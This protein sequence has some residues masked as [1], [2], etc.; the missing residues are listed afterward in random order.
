M[1]KLRSGVIIM[2][3]KEWFDERKR[4]RE[5]NIHSLQKQIE[6]FKRNMNEELSEEV[7]T[8]VELEKKVSKQKGMLHMLKRCYK[9][10]NK[11]P[12]NI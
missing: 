3:S 11:Q 9:Y 10:L 6:D 4:N 5:S 7:K 1:G 12:K 8:L 2:I